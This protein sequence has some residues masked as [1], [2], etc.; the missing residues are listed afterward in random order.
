[1]LGHRCPIVFKGLKKKKNGTDF[2]KLKFSYLVFLKK[3]KMWNLFVDILNF[4]EKI[5]FMV[6]PQTRDIRM[7]YE[8]TRVTYG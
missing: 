6:K 3:W 8:Y 1:M 4:C 7:T 2:T 5:G